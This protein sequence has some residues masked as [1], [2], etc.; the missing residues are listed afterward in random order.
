[1]SS[2]GIPWHSCP[3]SLNFTESW[4]RNNSTQ[5]HFPSN[6]IIIIYLFAT[7]YGRGRVVRRKERCYK[8]CYR[9]EENKVMALEKENPCSDW[10]Q[11]KA[12]SGGR[13][14]GRKASSPG[15]LWD[16]LDRKGRVGPPCGSKGA[17]PKARVNITIFKT[18]ASIISCEQIWPICLNI[19]KSPCLT[20]LRARWQPWPSGEL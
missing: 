15:S 4:L 14:S 16:L 9:E 8:R 1:M 19:V 11:R 7:S 2:S 5:C 17:W 10:G 3:L 6:V 13:A 20:A 12:R 18:L